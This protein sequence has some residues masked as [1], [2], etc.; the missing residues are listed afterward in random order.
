MSDEIRTGTTETLCDVLV[1]GGGTAGPMAAYKAKLRNPKARV[2]R[3]EGER[4]ALGC[5]QH[6]HGRRSEP[7]RKLRP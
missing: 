6:G 3:S 4:E 1:I 5:D 7:C 2:I